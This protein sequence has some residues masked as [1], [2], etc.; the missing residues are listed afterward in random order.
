MSKKSNFP[1]EILVKREISGEDSWLQ[2]VERDSEMEEDGQA[3]ATYQKV[4]VGHVRI[5][6]E[7]VE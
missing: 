4:S 3:I 1:D 2:V 5:T 6:K 7:I